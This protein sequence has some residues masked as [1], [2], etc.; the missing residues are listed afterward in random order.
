MPEGKAGAGCLAL[1]PFLPY[2]TWEQ[3]T[4]GIG[5]QRALVGREWM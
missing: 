4:V 2:R 5:W 3:R 1:D